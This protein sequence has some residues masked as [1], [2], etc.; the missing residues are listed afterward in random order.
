MHKEKYMGDD[1]HN[2][3]KS[4]FNIIEM[5]T[6]T[7]AIMAEIQAILIDVPLEKYRTE[8]ELRFW[9]A[10]FVNGVLYNSEVW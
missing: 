8:V 3:G 10:L 1:F 6:K 9:Q 5:C 4:W 2:S 7:Y